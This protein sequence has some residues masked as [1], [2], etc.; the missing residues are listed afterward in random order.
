M[1]FLKENRTWDL[2]D[3]P[4]GTQA[5]CGKWVY[6][7]KRGPD[8]SIVNIWLD[9]PWKALSNN[10]ELT[11]TRPMQPVKLTSYKCYLHCPPNTIG[12]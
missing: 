9:G 8:G 6:K 7:L 3:L 2:V 5:L 12:R 4:A 10:T 1:Q 11:M